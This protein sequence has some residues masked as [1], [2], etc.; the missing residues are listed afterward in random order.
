M[1]DQ[2][3]INAVSSGVFQP[4]CW[5]VGGLLAG[6]ALWRVVPWAPAVC[7]LLV[8][9]HVRP[10]CCPP[11]LAVCRHRCLAPLARV[12]PWP[13]AGLSS[14]FLRGRGRCLLCGSSPHERGFR[15]SSPCRV[16]RLGERRKEGLRLGHNLGPTECNLVSRTA[17]QL[18]VC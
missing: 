6:S 9:D 10:W 1:P 16:R 14:E 18:M 12:V 11:K 4:L 2:I 5:L 7:W 15:P 17:S 8:F 13:F 3:G